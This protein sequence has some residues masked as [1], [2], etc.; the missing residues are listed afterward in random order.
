MNDYRL[1]I[2]LRQADADAAPPALGADTARRVRRRRQRRIAVRSVATSLI[3]V[4]AM[5]WFW[6]HRP[7]PPKTIVA[8]H[9]EA[10]MRA[11]PPAVLLDAQTLKS[12]LA[13]CEA[14]ARLHELTAEAMLRLE[15]QE[16]ARHAVAPKPPD[17]LDV[18]GQLAVE[19]DIAAHVIVDRG[20]R[21]LKNPGGRA[22]AASAYRRVL[23]LFPD[24]REAA[25][26]RERL[27]Q[28]NNS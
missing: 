24:S 12:E 15:K 9:D 18:L 23:D 21:M 27:E 10:P 6:T 16:K 4:L 7:A 1:A 19:R 11:A 20:D 17:A 26:A 22:E 2:L 5:G 25:V 14:D 28:L 3:V 13:T 8:H